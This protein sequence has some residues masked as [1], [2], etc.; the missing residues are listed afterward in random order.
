[1]L[2]CASSFGNSS[3]SVKREYRELFNDYRNKIKEIIKSKKTDY[4]DFA[5]DGI[6]SE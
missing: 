2:Q 4:L 1:M 5:I 3:Y 6:S